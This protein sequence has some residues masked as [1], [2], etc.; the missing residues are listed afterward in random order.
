MA[1]RTRHRASAACV[2][3]AL[4]LSAASV[5]ARQH[6]PSTFHG[7]RAQMERWLA[8]H[9]LPAQCPLGRH[10]ESGSRYR[11]DVATAWSGC[12]A[13]GRYRDSDGRVRR[14]PMKAA[15]TPRP[16]S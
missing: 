10:P 12:I 3:V 6:Q 13:D 11:G 5:Q 8:A 2:L 14:L 1:S 7:T 9:P 15:K 16:A 4:L